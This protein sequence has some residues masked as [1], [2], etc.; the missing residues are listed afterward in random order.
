MK[1]SNKI[2]LL[3]TNV[4][5]HD[6]RC[7][8]NFQENDI[9]QIE[10]RGKRAGAILVPSHL[11]SEAPPYARAI[12]YQDKPP[13]SAPATETRQSVQDLLRQAI[14]N[15]QWRQT[16]CINLIPSEQTQSPMVRLL[17][18]MDP[19]FR[20]AEHRAVKAFGYEHNTLE[21]RN[22]TSPSIIVGINRMSSELLSRATWP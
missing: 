3:D 10:V 17:S 6:Y 22:M 18:V 7:I 13:K 1:K 4:L 11:S 8:Y 5:L 14:E 20:Y 19:A 21:S 9:V 16:Q 2:F 15:T 12:L